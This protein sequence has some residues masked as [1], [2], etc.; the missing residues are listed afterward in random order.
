ME[1]LALALGAALAI[2][3]TGLATGIAQARIGSAGV[4]AISERP[5]S[6]AS[7]LILMAIPETVVI[8][9]FVVAVMIMLVLP[10][11]TP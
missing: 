7:S 2:G 1:I 9:G 4:G 3:L 11:Q 8:L 10:G 6:F 5:E